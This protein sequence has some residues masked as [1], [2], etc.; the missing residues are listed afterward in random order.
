MEIENQSFLAKT[1]FLLFLEVE[2]YAYTDYDYN[3][4]NY[5]DL[6]EY[7]AEGEIKP[8]DR[9][10]GVYQNQKRCSSTAKIKLN[11]G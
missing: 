10:K 5:D 4:Y 8:G 3:N 2:E 7:Y 1:H 9:V 6:G 11:F